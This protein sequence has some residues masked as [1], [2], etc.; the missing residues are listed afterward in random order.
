MTV[1]VAGAYKDLPDLSV[2]HN[3][4]RG[5]RRYPNFFLMFEMASKTEL[6]SRVRLC[7]ARL[8]QLVVSVH[9]AQR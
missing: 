2:M 3:A 8:G 4:A 7:T 1:L 6:L 5:A 9:V